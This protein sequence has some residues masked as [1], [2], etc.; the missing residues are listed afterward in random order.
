MREDELTEY[1]M[2]KRHG[3]AGQRQSIGRERDKHWLGLFHLFPKA[4]ATVKT[5]GELWGTFGSKRLAL[6]SL[7][8]QNLCVSIN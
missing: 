4:Q 6:G 5:E 7:L 1:P 3:S 8:S 2:G